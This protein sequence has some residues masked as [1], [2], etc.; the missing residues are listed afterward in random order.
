MDGFGPFKGIKAK[1]DFKPNLI[2]NILYKY[3]SWGKKNDFL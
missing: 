2:N 3:F 1:F